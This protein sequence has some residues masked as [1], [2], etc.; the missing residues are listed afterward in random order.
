MRQP[1]AIYTSI[2]F[3]FTLLAGCS[4]WT[5]AAD[6][7]GFGFGSIGHALKR[8]AR[9]PDFRPPSNG[10]SSGHSSRGSSHDR[11]GGG[12]GGGSDGSGGGGSDSDD[13]SY[14]SDSATSKDDKKANKAAE[15]RLEA[16]K[17]AKNLYRN[18]KEIAEQNKARILERGR[19]VDQAIKDFIGKLT[20]LHKGLR[21]LTG[22]DAKVAAGTNINEV[23]EGSVKNAIEAAYDKA[24]FNEFASLAGEMWTRDRLLVRIVD[25]AQSRL[26]GYFN[27]VGAQGPSM[28]DLKNDV[29][30]KSAHY[31]RGTA[32]EVSEIIGVSHS[33]DRFIRTVYESVETGKSSPLATGGDSRYE[34]FVTAAINSVPLK[35]FVKQGGAVAADAAG[36]E[37]NFQFRFRARRVLYDCLSSNVPQLI[38][39]GGGKTIDAAY[40]A[41]AGAAG[42]TGGRGAQIDTAPESGPASN[43]TTGALGK[44]EAL[45]QTE[46][47]WAQAQQQ[48]GS[49]CGS[50]IASLA[51]QK[52]HPVPAHWTSTGEAEPEPSPADKIPADGQNAPSSNDAAGQEE[53]AN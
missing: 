3:V 38:R 34:R 25:D 17:A 31:V 30:P 50:R 36:L 21:K 27:G 52:V 16:A 5:P 33:Y 40:Q 46:V 29:F 13:S 32:L 48:L 45:K 39:Q 42:E 9:I 51:G 28:T 43:I 7:R 47:V 23:T 35:N 10:G 4:L 12:G 19:D 44:A 49:A 15:A 26:G 6:S 1:K 53:N 41:P 37:R 20:G 18:R 14:S 11:G 24:E 2:F 22:V 8:A